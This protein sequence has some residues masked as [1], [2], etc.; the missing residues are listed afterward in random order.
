MLLHPSSPPSS[1]PPSRFLSFSPSRKR[2]AALGNAYMKTL[3]RLVPS[4]W[5]AAAVWW[6]RATVPQT[7]PSCCLLV[8]A[9]K[10]TGRKLPFPTEKPPQY[11]SSSH[12]SI[13]PPHTLSMPDH[14]LLCFPLCSK[15]F[16]PCMSHC[17]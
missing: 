9:R 3:S 15:S 7:Q 12:Q 2:V 10:Q 8:S 6:S 4:S 14:P 1:P 13:H 11:P 16:L 5:A 17:C